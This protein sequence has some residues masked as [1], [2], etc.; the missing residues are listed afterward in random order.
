M[1]YRENLM[2]AYRFQKPDWVPMATGIPPILWKDADYDPVELENLLLTHPKLFPGYKKGSVTPD[3]IYIPADMYKGVPYTDGWGCVWETSYTGM[4]GAV[5]THALDDW[6]KFAA[7]KAPNPEVHNGMYAID[8]K[9]IKADG[10]QAKRDGWIFAC[11][12]PHGHTFL[13]IQDLRGYTNFLYDMMDDDP[14]LHLLINM[15]ETFN[16]E[17]IKRYI[18]L[19]PDMITIAEDLG[20]QNSPMISPDLFRRFIKPVYLKMTSPVKRAGIIVHEHSDG[21]IMDLMDD[22]IECGGD[23]INMQDLV[24]GIDNL[25]KHVKGRI[26]IDLDIDRQSVTVDGTPADI[27]AHIKE[28]VVKLGSPEGGLSLCYQPWPP[29]PIENMR[30]VFDAMEKYTTCHS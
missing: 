7:F 12:L 14:R 3:N 10:E 23:V 26:A 25:A 2:R 4:V 19:Q 24:N 6:S 28:C 1:N 21:Y 11:H 9:K 20:M 17:L 22:L 27:D 18:A 8:L 13:R 29:T 30:A 5:K 15:V 16:I